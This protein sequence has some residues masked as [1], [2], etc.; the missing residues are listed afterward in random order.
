MSSTP[1]PGGRGKFKGPDALI[2]QTE[3]YD[4]RA[5]LSN[6]ESIPGQA[7]YKLTTGYYA[8]RGG[9]VNSAN[10]LIQ[11]TSAAVKG[12][13][14]F[15]TSAYDEVNNRLGIGTQAP[16]TTLDVRGNGAFT[17]EVTAPT[18]QG[19]TAS[20]GGLTLQS[21]SHATKGK[22]LFGTSAYDEVNNRLGIKTATPGYA[23]E[24]TGN[25][26][27]AG[28]I[29]AARND[30]NAFIEF[31]P[32]GG[33]GAVRYWMGATRSGSAITAAGSFFIWDESSTAAR[34]II[35]SAGKI[36]IGGAPSASC[37]L[38]VQST[39]G[40]LMLPRMTTVQRN[41]LTA[42]DGMLVYNTTD[43]KVQARAGGAWVDLH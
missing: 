22:I 35:D 42:A 19:S 30:P 11:S 31:T 26:Y 12:L 28:I 14:K 34:L 17:S 16:A 1:I 10:L 36:G 8:L 3:S 23:L 7:I 39:T 15:G 2:A 43:S 9:L 32:Q 5:R 13:I 37:A 24:V 41:A 20:G 4:F 25:S 21:T 33:S 29:Y 27:I 40:A 18:V 38:D 6:L